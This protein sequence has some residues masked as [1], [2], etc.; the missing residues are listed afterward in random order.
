MCLH[1]LI[2]HSRKENKM[3]HI[4]MVAKQRPDYWVVIED[5]KT[6]V[7]HAPTQKIAE[8]RRAEWKRYNGPPVPELSRMFDFGPRRPRQ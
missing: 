1:D 4:Y 3:K 6:I 7:D 2:G 5:G 8:K